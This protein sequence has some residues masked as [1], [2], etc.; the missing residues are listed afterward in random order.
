MAVNIKVKIKLFDL[1][2]N[3]AGKKEI[4]FDIPLNTSLEDV[5][6]LL[7]NSYPEVKNL[8]V[9][10]DGKYTSFLLVY[11][12]SVELNSQNYKSFPVED[13]SEIMLILPGV[14]G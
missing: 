11:N 12:N 13:N 10:E 4:I 14:G 6:Q 1:L 9:N 3:L 2:A 5:I 8:L 7:F